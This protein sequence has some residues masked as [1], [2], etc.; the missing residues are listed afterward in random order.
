MPTLIKY[1][2]Y[3]NIKKNNVKVYY[4]NMHTLYYLYKIYRGKVLGL[5]ILFKSND[6]DIYSKHVFTVIVD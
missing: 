4:K 6:V 2:M 1:Q 3:A 5:K